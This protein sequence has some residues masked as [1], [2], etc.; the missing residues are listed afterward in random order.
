[1]AI[2]FNE[3]IRYQQS[4]P[5]DKTRTTLLRRWFSSAIALAMPKENRLAL[6]SCS[7]FTMG[8]I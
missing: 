1:M 7:R 2:N 4:H 3:A 6:E 5:L 8:M